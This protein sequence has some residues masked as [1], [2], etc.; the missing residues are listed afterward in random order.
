MFFSK[1]HPKQR[2]GVRTPWTSPW[3]RPVSDMDHVRCRIYI[4]KIFSYLTTATRYDLDL[5]DAD[6]NQCD[7]R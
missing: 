5:V 6:V 4:A 1:G 2:A 3:I 7:L